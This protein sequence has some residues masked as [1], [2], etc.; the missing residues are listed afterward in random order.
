L[1]KDLPYYATT[2][3]KGVRSCYQIPDVTNTFIQKGGASVRTGFY[4]CSRCKRRLTII[5]KTPT[6]STKLGLSKLLLASY[7]IVKASKGISSVYLGKMISIS[8]K[9]AW[10]LGHAIQ[11]MMDPGNELLLPGANLK[12]FSLIFN[13][14]T[15]LFV[16]EIIKIYFEHPFISFPSDSISR[17]KR[18]GVR[19]NKFKI[20]S[21][22]VISRGEF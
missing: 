5:T 14:K 1:I 18:V 10:K 20:L 3:K 22:Q 15:L 8:Q 9:S 19:V 2:S 4:K 21:S 6:H 17:C 16:S 11:S 7:L 12:P 13:Y